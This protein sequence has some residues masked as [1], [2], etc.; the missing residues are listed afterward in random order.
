MRPE[1]GTFGRDCVKWESQ[2]SQRND[3]SS[4]SGKEQYLIDGGWIQNGRGWWHPP[5]CL[6]SWPLDDAYRMAKQDERNGI[7]MNKEEVEAYLRD[8]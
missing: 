7:R 6:A 2:E 5:S 8:Q 4:D 3:E 1:D